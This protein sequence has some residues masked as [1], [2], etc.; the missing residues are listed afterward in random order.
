MMIFFCALLLLLVGA[1]AWPTQHYGVDVS[2][3]VSLSEW[4]CLL[5]QGLE[6]GIV[7]VF[8]SLGSVDPAAVQTIANGHKAGVRM[9][10]YMFPCPKC[11]TTGA[12]QVATLMKHLNASGAVIG[13]LWFDVEG[14]SPYW[15]SSHSTN[16]Q[17]FESLLHGAAQHGLAA[18]VYCN[19]VQ[20]P[21]IFGSS[22]NMPNVGSALLWYPHYDGKPQFTDFK[23]FGGFSA[24]NIQIKQFSDK[25][26]KCTASYDINWRPTL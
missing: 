23:P 26:A 22:Y 1:I 17:F 19:W 25:G 5:Q 24:S 14:A 18:G 15:T 11:G 3:P 20:W 6:F 9:D 8:R 16:Q 12:D 4:Q 10:G 21:A 7:R 2:Q 13:T